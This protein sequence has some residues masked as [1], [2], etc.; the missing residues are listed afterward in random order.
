MIDYVKLNFFSVDRIMSAA[1]EQRSLIRDFYDKPH[2]WSD[3][4][5]R[6]KI[7]DSCKTHGDLRYLKFEIPS[8]PF[9]DVEN[10]YTVAFNGLYV[11]KKLRNGKPLLVHQASKSNLSGETEHGH[12]E[13]NIDD[14]ELLSYLYNA[15]MISNDLTIYRDNPVLLDL[16]QEHL[17]VEAAAKLETPID[18]SSL[19]SSQKKGVVNQ[20]VK[21]NLLGDAYFE[22][23]RLI[24]KINDKSTLSSYKIPTILRN[25]LLNPDPSLSSQEKIVLWQ[26]LCNINGANPVL[27]YLFDKTNFYEQY[28]AWDESSQ[29]W[30]INLI[31]KHKHIFNQLI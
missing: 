15:G 3:D 11:F 26:L 30:I 13:Y 8:H 10:F 16:M 1:K 27:T 25:Y 2:A 5:L 29:Q 12:M 17:L 14:P 31:L 23:E 18:F 22:F 28:K 9:N 19:N 6:Q 24:N 21:K 20:L 7:I 4:E